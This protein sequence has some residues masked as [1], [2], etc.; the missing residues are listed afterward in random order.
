V[1]SASFSEVTCIAEWFGRGDE[2]AGSA[3]L[4]VVDLISDVAS[5]LLFGE[6]FPK[7]SSGAGS[8]KLFDF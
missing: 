4:S 7:F 5:E 2:A 6:D 3:S 8:L 1:G